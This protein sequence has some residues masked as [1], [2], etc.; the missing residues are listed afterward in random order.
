MKCP[1][2]HKRMERGFSLRLM[3]P[4]WY[5]ES[6]EITRVSREGKVSAKS[7]TLLANGR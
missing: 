7:L 4:T 5:C 1:K 3:K 2:C 6:C